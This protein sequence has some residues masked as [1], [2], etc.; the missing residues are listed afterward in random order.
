PAPVTPMPPSPQMAESSQA[1]ELSDLPPSVHETNV[2]GTEVASFDESPAE[3]VPTEPYFRQESVPRVAEEDDHVELPDL[4]RALGLT[5]AE[6]DV[7][8]QMPTPARVVT[9]A[10][11][12]KRAPSAGN[13]PQL[14]LDYES[15]PPPLVSELEPSESL[16]RATRIASPPPPAEAPVS[17]ASNPSEGQSLE[18]EEALEST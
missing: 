12:K 15:S 8:H 2:L 9:S 10:L 16:P 17:D 6:P 5:A 3:E 13:S 4:D 14:A 1:M 18:D 11:T 7:A